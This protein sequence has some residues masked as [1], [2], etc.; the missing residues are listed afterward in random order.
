MSELYVLIEHCFV[1]MECQMSFSGPYFLIWNVNVYCTR[2]GRCE[3]KPGYLQNAEG[4]R[5]PLNV[6]VEYCLTARCIY[7]A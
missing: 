2:A 7:H 1:G 6:Q 5:D 4:G 3:D